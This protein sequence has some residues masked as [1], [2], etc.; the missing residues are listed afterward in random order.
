MPNAALPLGLAWTSPFAKWGG[1]LAGLSSIDVAHAVTAL[2]LER[3][4]VDPAIVD[5]LVLGWTVPAPDIFYG[6]PSL[7]ARLGMPAVSG[8]MLSQACATS[9]AAVR[10]AAASIQ[11]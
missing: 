10:A 6:A 3:R 2:A 7:A 4:Q 9:V 8:P 5:E 1:T 11:Q